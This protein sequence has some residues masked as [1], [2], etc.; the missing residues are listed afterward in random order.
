[1][2]SGPRPIPKADESPVHRFDRRTFF[3]QELNLAMV[4]DEHAIA[5]EAFAVANHHSYFAQLARELHASGNHVG[6]SLLAAYHLEQP[7]NVRRSEEMRA[8]HELGP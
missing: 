7:R 4:R 1:M 3:D 2:A 6:R 8:Y 5:H